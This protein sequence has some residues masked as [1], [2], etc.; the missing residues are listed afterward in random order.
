MSDANLQQLGIKEDM[1][2]T[3]FFTRK[4]PKTDLQQCSK[5]N[6]EWGEYKS[7]LLVQYILNNSSI[8]NKL[9]NFV[10]NYIKKFYDI[11]TS[12]NFIDDF[13]IFLENAKESGREIG[14][15]HSANKYGVGQSQIIGH[16]DQTMENLLQDPTKLNNIV[17]FSS[18]IS[19]QLYFGNTKSIFN[20]KQ[21]IDIS[22]NI[23]EIN[24]KL[25]DKKSPDGEN[26]FFNIINMFMILEVIQQ[27]I[28]NAQ[29]GIKGRRYNRKLDNAVKTKQVGISQIY[30]ED[31][32]I[33][34]FKGREFE[35]GLRRTIKDLDQYIVPWPHP[36]VEQCKCTYTGIWGEHIKENLEK[37]ELI[38]CVQCGLS[39]SILFN[40]YSYLYSYTTSF[41]KNPKKDFENLLLTSI[42]T[43]VGDGGHN[44]MEVV[45]G[46][47]FAIIILYNIL[48][49]LEE[50][51]QSHYRNKYSLSDN[52]KK[53]MEENDDVLYSIVQEY[54]V[55]SILFNKVEINEGYYQ[56]YFVNCE[57]A[58]IFWGGNNLFK[59]FIQNW[60]YWEQ[61]IREA[62]NLTKNFNLTGVSEED[63]DVYNP[64]LIIDWPITT[65]RKEL[66]SV[67]L[68]GRK[69]S[70]PFEMNII[71]PEYND[72][73]QIALA[74][75][76]N[77]Y[78]G[79]KENWE[80]SPTKLVTDILEK[81][82]DG[83]S[84]GLNM[85]T[86]ELTRK[87]EKCKYDTYQVK[88]IP[89]A[90]PAPKPQKNYR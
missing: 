20:V 42:V 11:F 66:I 89:F 2:D 44:I 65:E 21:N 85:I 68:T 41:P 12:N 83:S 9:N 7:S 78:K 17:M 88:D 45:Y 63:L 26:E 49:S 51:L 25:N 79:G 60:V 36:G 69:I 55:L 28:M 46:Y 73:L 67:I 50:E 64:D 29:I 24:K 30:E 71:D 76:N 57:L 48:I 47:V 22:E 19:H 81:Y 23:R 38:A 10:Y 40:L 43:L 77:R 27:P 13:T 70:S 32:D 72:Y 8:Q 5:K 31:Q 84:V 1:D 86:E 87:M 62:Y 37:D 35:Y 61:F 18:F 82:T 14:G 80:I 3:E 75:D 56:T 74:M 16:G 58:K 54:T 53:L 6:Y 59:K 90:F 39:G 52:V 33:P 4:T 15:K 34:Q